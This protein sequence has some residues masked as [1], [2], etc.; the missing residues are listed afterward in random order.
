[1]RPEIDRQRVLRPFFRFLA[2]PLAIGGWIFLGLLIYHF[3]SDNTSAQEIW[4][5][6]LITFSSGL[7]TLAVTQGRIPRW[8]FRIIPYSHAWEG[9]KTRKG[10]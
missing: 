5:I 10:R 1:M 2:A 9:Q 4:V 8:M 3:D 7:F 6:S